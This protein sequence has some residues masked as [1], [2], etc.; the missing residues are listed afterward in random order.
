MKQQSLERI[1][2]NQTEQGFWLVPSIFK[3]FTPKSRNFVIKFSKSLEDLIEQ[4]KL[5]NREIKFS[6]NGDKNFILFNKL[7]KQREWDFELPANKINKMKE[8]DY[9]DYEVIPNLKIRF[10]FKT[11]NN[12][13]KGN[14][15]FVSNEYFQEFYNKNKTSDNDILILEWT[16]W[17][18]NII[19]NPD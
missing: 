16:N 15:F 12:I 2:V 9:I 6:F 3:L 17:D 14:I 4:N 1:K 19:K 7:I 8:D 11:I 5:L 18:F 13:Y 10:N